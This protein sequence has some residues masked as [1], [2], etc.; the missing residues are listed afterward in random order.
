MINHIYDFDY[1]KIINLATAKI[2]PLGYKPEDYYVIDDKIP[3]RIALEVIKE[4]KH[5]IK[6]EKYK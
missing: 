4:I 5:L 3:L 1:D 2:L 6:M